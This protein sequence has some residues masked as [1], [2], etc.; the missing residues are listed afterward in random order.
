[1]E[2]DLIKKE[3]IEVLRNVLNSISDRNRDIIFKRFGF[4]GEDIMTL[5]EIGKLYGVSKERIRKLESKTLK[6]LKT[7]VE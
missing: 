3:E 4:D 1:M 5:E 6:F 2:D 7:S